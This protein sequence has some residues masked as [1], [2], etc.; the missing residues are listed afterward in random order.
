[1]DRFDAM[2]VFTRIV[3]LGS[4]TK[5]AADLRLP[6]AT[7][8]LAVQQLEAR[9]GVRLLHRT[10]REVNPTSEGLL[11]YRRCTRVLTEVQDAEAELGQG[12][13]K[14]RGKVR[15]HMVAGMAAHVVIPALREFH[16]RHPQ[17]DVEVGTGDR[18]VDLAKEGVD[19]ALRAGNV[20][21]P[22]LIVRRLAPMLQI[23]CAS[24]GYLT[25]HGEPRSLEALERHWAV[26]YLEHSTGKPYPLE[27]VVRGELKK[28]SM[29]GIL[30]VMDSEAYSSGC[31]AHF[32]LI[33]VPAYRLAA[34]LAE[35]RLREVLP[36][37]RPPPLPLSL[38]HP[39]QRKVP[40]RVRVFMDWLTA[41]CARQLGTTS[42]ESHPED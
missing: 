27:F 15:V 13:G 41:L 26:N 31:L 30:T 16:E 22:H 7:V 23:T 37:A 32:G 2:R 12:G 14:L 42:G 38:V 36:N 39:Y 19:C 17:V 34:H 6:R 1:M 21:T 35:G 8:T 25:R 20:D 10:T 29:N 24:A 3:E 5:A 9:L 18:A 4:F 33:Q 40:P 11:F 28:V